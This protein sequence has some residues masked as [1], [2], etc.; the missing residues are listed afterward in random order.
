MKKWLNTLM[1]GCLEAF[2][3]VPL[4]LLYGLSDAGCFVVHR[5][6]GYRRK[7][8]AGNIARA[9]PEK[10]EA[11]RRE[12]ERRFYRFFCDYAVE[13]LKLLTVGR[14]EIRRRMVFEGVEEV[15]R[16]LS[17]HPLAF[18]YLGHYCNWEWISTLP[19]WVSA[20][21]HCAQIYRPLNNKAFEDLFMR[22]RTRF[23]AENI[24]KYAAVHRIL[25]LKVQGVKTVV[26]F[27]SDQAPSGT[28]HDWLEFLHQDTAVYTGAES[29]GKRV[30]A[31]MFFADV[32]RPRRGY[33]RCRLRLLTDDV[34]SMEDYKVTELYM[35]E[36][37]SMIRRAPHLWLW[38]HRR[39]KYRRPAGRKP[40]EAD[41]AEAR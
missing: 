18:V 11:E 20:D 26:G 23:G 8:V 41:G 40:A 13:T 21:V 5:V 14:E 19:A 29:I 24:A 27:I 33:Y 34:R 17:S 39:W 7:V 31:A 36:L 28:I 32:E 25:S 38:S 16:Q 15:E 30:D 3:R 2:S 4:P 12:I 1:E 22:L 9:F 6:L 37:E 10:P 35:R